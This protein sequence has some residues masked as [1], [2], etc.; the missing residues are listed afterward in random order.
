L[1]IAVEA[2]AGVVSTA[3]ARI[4]TAVTDDATSFVIAYGAYVLSLAWGGTPLPK[5][6]LCV[7]G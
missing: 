3:V 4:T 5:V 1:V 6:V 7:P 2:I